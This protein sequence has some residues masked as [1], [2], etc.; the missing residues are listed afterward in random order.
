MPRQ[1]RA[2]DSR[3]KFSDSLEGLQLAEIDMGSIHGVISIVR[4]QQCIDRGKI[5]QCL[6]GRQADDRIG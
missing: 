5:I 6:T 3:R 1:R 4:C 2:L